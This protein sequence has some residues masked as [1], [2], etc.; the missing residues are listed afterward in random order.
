[1]R[2]MGWTQMEAASADPLGP[3]SQ[4]IPDV[5]RP[6]TACPNASVTFKETEVSHTT[7]D[8]SLHQTTLITFRSLM[9][10]LKKKKSC[11]HSSKLKQ[12]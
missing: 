4:H 10:R 5:Q 12:I 9:E 1:M 6:N 2:F 3:N 11:E 7:N 8:A